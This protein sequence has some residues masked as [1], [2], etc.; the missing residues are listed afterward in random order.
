MMTKEYESLMFELKQALKNVCADQAYT[1]LLYQQNLVDLTYH[2]TRI[3]GNVLDR[4]ETLLLLRDKVPPEGKNPICSQMSEDHHSALLRIADDAYNSNHKFSVTYL[5]LISGLVLRR[6]GSKH[7]TALGTTDESKGDFRLHSVHIDGH[8][9]ISYSEIYSTVIRFTE[10]VHEMMSTISKSSDRVPL[11]VRLAI[12][13]HFSIVEIHP[14]SD[15]NGRTAR[16]IMNYILLKYDLPLLVVDSDSRD[17]YIS[18]LKECRV[19]GSTD[20]IIL[21]LMKEYMRSLKDY[22]WN[23]IL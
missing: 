15:G 3:E 18:A 14:F 19:N 6:T 2:S 11:V 10:R 7:N 21:F 23:S 20:P 5:Q 17:K 16:L 9:F 4:D 22:K 1:N 13:C 8:Y 12:F